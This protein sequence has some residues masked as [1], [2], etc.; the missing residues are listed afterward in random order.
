LIEQLSVDD[1]DFFNKWR[2]N[3]Y[4]LSEDQHL[5]LSNQLADKYPHQKHFNEAIFLKEFQILS[6]RLGQGISVLEVGGWKGELAS[7]ILSKYPNIES[8][9][10]IDICS[11]TIINNVCLDPRYLK[12]IASRFNWFEENRS[13]PFHVCVC[14]H[15]IE[16]LSWTD[17]IGLIDYMDGIPTIIF[18]APISQE[19]G[20]LWNNYPGT[21]ILEVGWKTINSYM[22]DL[23]YSVTQLS[24]FVYRYERLP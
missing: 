7:T 23:G 4:V 24:E 21:H 19:D 12:K 20:E 14:A 16:H 5:L 15:T 18:E 6:D 8:W 11:A 13:N 17:L 9:M 3:Y 1:V 10:D 22:Q 2:K